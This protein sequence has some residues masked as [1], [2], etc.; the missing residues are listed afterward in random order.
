M[1]DHCLK[2]TLGIVDDPHVLVNVISGRAKML[3]RGNRPLV[4]SL[5]KLSPEHIAPPGVIEAR[6]THV[7][8][9]IVTP[10]H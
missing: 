1:R 7:M 6:I 3:R 5:E 2:E 4:E 8:G 9:S 10:A